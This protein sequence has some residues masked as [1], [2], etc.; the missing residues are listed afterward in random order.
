MKQLPLLNLFKDLDG[1]GIVPTKRGNLNVG[2][3]IFGKL[4]KR[5]RAQGAIKAGTRPGAGLRENK[6]EGESLEKIM[7]EASRLLGPLEVGEGFAFRFIL[8]LSG[9]R[10]SSDTAKDLIARA[11][12]R[13]GLVRL[14]KLLRLAREAGLWDTGSQEDKKSIPFHE[15]PE[16]GK[17]LFRLGLKAED[18]NKI[19]QGTKSPEGIS[20]DKLQERLQSFLSGLGKEGFTEW[21]G[22][23]G[24]DTRQRD[25]EMVLRDQGV[26]D[27]MAQA[28]KGGQAPEAV[29][30]RL[31]TAL[32]EQ[33]F[34]PEEVKAILEKLS[35]AELK[36]AKTVSP[37]PE[38]E[39]ILEAL[40]KELEGIAEKKMKGVRHPPK[41]FGRNSLV[42]K[43]GVVSK[44]NPG[45]LRVKDS[46]GEQV[47][48]G[49]SVAELLSK[50]LGSTKEAG[51]YNPLEKDS[52]DG[53]F[54]KKIGALIEA[55]RDCQPGGVLL[56]SLDSRIEAPATQSAYLGPITHHETIT[57]IMERLRLM[58]RGG[59][60]KA[61]IN[62]HPPELGRLEI[63][64]EVKDG[65]LHARL[66]AEHAWVKELIEGN[67]NQLRQQLSDLGLVVENFQ[68]RVG[69]GDKGVKD[70]E[71]HLWARAKRASGKGKNQASLEVQRAEDLSGGESLVHV[72]A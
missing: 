50:N 52:G 4:L 14:D 27:L 40:L 60:Q 34:R 70:G 44:F 42:E 28:L 36:N 57:K 49:N 63:R 66:G 1:P 71:G 45:D 12:D 56:S 11:S 16:M 3:G 62:L 19:L 61:T 53:I 26:G 21:I 48:K 2:K 29:K 35:I 24:V 59:E 31:A 65:V 55:S 7:E 51:I 46:S 37:S 20:V 5:V 41:A 22:R 18:V 6:I 47:L 15:I 25:L 23:L 8:A 10:A 64:V 69:L 58:V 9:F 54:L 32:R 13:N 43:D 72:V 67:V 68:V 39:R 17:L 33:G 30:L 38:G